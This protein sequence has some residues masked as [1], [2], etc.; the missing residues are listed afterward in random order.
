MLAA[1]SNCRKNLSSAGTSC[2]PWRIFNSWQPFFCLILSL[3]ILNTSFVLV[4]FYCHDKHQVQKQLGIERVLKL[5]LPGYS[6]SLGEVSSGV[7]AGIEAETKVFLPRDGTPLLW[8]EPPH[9]NHP[10][11]HSLLS[12]DQS[13]GV[14][15]SAKFHSSQVI[16]ICVQLVPNLE[17]IANRY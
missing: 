7:L 3:S 16:L 13:E 1:Q 11:R 6:Q 2:N 12:I 15:S 10:W 4:T 5:L 8:V 14:N 17:C 9:I